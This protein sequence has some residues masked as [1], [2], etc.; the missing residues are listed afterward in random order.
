MMH[1]VIV[2]D[3]GKV[4][5][6][7]CNILEKIQKELSEIEDR[8]FDDIFPSYREYSMLYAIEN[9]GTDPG[10]IQTNDVR[11]CSSNVTT[12]TFLLANHAGESHLFMVVF[13]L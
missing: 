3:H 4:V 11:V 7:T 1:A 6:A 10:H 13:Q 2:D 5:V 9:V 12:K 8:L